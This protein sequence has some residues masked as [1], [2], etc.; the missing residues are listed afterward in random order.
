[1]SIFLKSV[2]KIQVSLK[3]DKNNKPALHMQTDGPDSYCHILLKFSYNGKCF[4][5]N[6]TENQ[7][8]F[9]VQQLFQK[10]K[11]C[12]LCGNVG[13]FGGAGQATDGNIMWRMRTG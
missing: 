2:D 6:L 11:S 13:S 1:L 7:N 5:Q 9:C 8:T 12:C 3:S 4:G 10:K